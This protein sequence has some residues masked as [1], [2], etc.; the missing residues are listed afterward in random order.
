M[1]SPLDKIPQCADRLDPP[2]LVEARSLL[3][4]IIN[5][6]INFLQNSYDV[7]DEVGNNKTRKGKKVGGI[8]LWNTSVGCYN[9]LSCWRCL[10]LKEAYSTRHMVW[11]RGI[12][13]M[14]STCTDRAPDATLS[15]LMLRLWS[16]DVRLTEAHIWDQDCSPDIPP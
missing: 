10:L 11:V 15:G 6:R 4:E 7:F 12:G 1:D 5:A 9:T 14:Q 8:T 13:T 16:L 2:K 3:L